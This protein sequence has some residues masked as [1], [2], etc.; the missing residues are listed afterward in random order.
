[1]TKL[2]CPI[3]GVEMS[4]DIHAPEDGAKWNPTYPDIST[5]EFR[6]MDNWICVHDSDNHC[7]VFTREDI[8]GWK[9]DG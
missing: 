4:A 2:Y 1:M 5:E 9:L 3:C 8:K 7:V 6:K